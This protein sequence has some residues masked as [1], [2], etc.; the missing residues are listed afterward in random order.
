MTQYLNNLKGLS[1]DP[2]VLE[3]CLAEHADANSRRADLQPNYQ[4][5][6]Q[7]QQ[8]SYMPQQFDLQQ[9]QQQQYLQQQ[10]SY[11]PQ[12]T[13]HQ[14]QLYF[15]QE[16]ALNIPPQ[17]HPQ[18][19]GLG[20]YETG[21]NDGRNREAD[22]SA[23]DG[24]DESADEGGDESESLLHVTDPSST[25]RKRPYLYEVHARTPEQTIIETAQAESIIQATMEIVNRT[26]DMRLNE[27]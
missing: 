25:V 26:L 20:D 24:G 19:E 18:Q 16:E 15:Q 2:D 10:Q 5:Q 3:K 9:Q 1:D 21:N 6:Y 4:Q 14:Q 23:D 22:E 7:Q 8:V 27:R 11:I 17:Q 12:Q 13:D